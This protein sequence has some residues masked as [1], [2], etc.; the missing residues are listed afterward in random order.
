MVAVQRHA[1]AL[2]T[3]V[4]GTALVVV[5]AGGTLAASNP[6]TLY[7]C[8]DAYGN[9]RMGDTPQCRLPGGRLVSWSTTAVPGPPGPKG[10]TGP[11]GPTGP[12]GISGYEVVHATPSKPGDGFSDVLYVHAA[13]PSGKL[14][15]GGGGFA[16]SLPAVGP[17]QD[18]VL[19]ASFTGSGSEWIWGSR[20]AMA[21]SSSRRT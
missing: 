19:A 5:A 3:A 20:R 21:P 7:A 17:L 10:A 13:C 12:V 14:A 9:V 11:T 15:L 16:V 1:R 2:A 4:A 8:Y 18:L 6:P